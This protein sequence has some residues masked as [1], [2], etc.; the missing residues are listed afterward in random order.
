MANIK[1]HY[2]DVRARAEAARWILEYAG[3]KYE[4]IRYSIEEWPEI[5]SS[6]LLIK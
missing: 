6:K 5:K 4:D 2:F 1:L 3:A